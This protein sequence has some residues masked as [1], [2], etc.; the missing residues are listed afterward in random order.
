VLVA[1]DA[2]NVN[3]INIIDCLPG[4]KKATGFTGGF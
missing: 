2:K 1:F 3:T 4:N